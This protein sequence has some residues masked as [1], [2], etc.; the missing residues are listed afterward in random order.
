MKRRNP[1]NLR[2][3]AAAVL[4]VAFLLLV[5]ACS[6]AGTTTTT[7]PP[8]ATTTTAGGTATTAGGGASTTAAPAAEKPKMVVA[9]SDTPNLVELHT[10]R[11]TSAYAVTKALYEPLLRQKLTPDASGLLMGSPTEY[12]GLG[13]ESFDIET[14]ADGGMKG[15][16]H[17][18]TD[19]KFPDGTPVTAEDYKYT[20]DRTIEGPGYI[21]LLL[22]FIGIDSTDQIKVL[23]DHTLEITTKVQ[24][25]LFRRFMTFQV[26]GAIE[27]KVAD[28]HA[29][30]DDPWTFQY[31]NDH[32][33]GSGPFMLEEFNPDQQVVLAPNPE[34]WDAA[35]VANSGVVIRT[36][37]DANQRALLVRNGELDLV[38]GIPARL[39]KDMVNDPNVKVYRA[40]SSG[41]VY[42]AMNETISPMDNVDLRRAIVK[43]VPYDALIDQVMFGF[44]QPA[45]GVVTT[46]METYDPQIGGRYTTD[47][48]GAKAALAA[49]GLQNVTLELGVRQSRQ[50][51]QDAAVLIQ[52]SLRQI[53]INVD[54]QVLPDADFADK[55][56][57]N[58]LPLFIHDWYSWGEDPFYQM[59]FL[60]TCGQFVNYARFCNE[61]YDALVQQGTFT[62]DPAQR[63][64]LSSQ[65]QQIFYDQAVWAPLWS[66]DRTVVTGKCV[67]GVD[68]DFT[69]VPGFEYLTKT[70]SC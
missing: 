11:T 65:A 16:F 43:A 9:L 44:A 20:F 31:F 47:L 22:P 1:T 68:R 19:A 14:T 57:N 46:S 35:S 48:D 50:E 28:E 55:I 36:V 51:D 52:D 33:A 29:T 21:G 15:T 39:L 10:F 63:A 62:L 53:G 12:E 67:T 17:L 8:A 69:L 41:V 42:L 37:P 30:T 32:A 27:K 25:P 61:D 45:R 13:A 56:N 59:K 23:D 24:S 5:T 54:V 7:A 70:D 4:V 18:R 34:Y 60:T 3:H 40:P 38:T 6:S 49:S 2:R 26:F 64:D 66:A 58:E